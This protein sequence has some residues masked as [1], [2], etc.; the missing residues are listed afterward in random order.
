MRVVELLAL[1][2]GKV[3]VIGGGLGSGRLGGA[4]WLFEG[5]WWKR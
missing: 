2:L 4:L 5:G 1:S 3:K